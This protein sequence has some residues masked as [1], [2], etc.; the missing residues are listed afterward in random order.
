VVV[1][2]ADFHKGWRSMVG[3][4]KRTKLDPSPQQPALSSKDQNP[5]SFKRVTMGIKKGSNATATKK[6]GNNGINVY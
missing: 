4:G 6:R 2:L 5:S 1:N 3:L